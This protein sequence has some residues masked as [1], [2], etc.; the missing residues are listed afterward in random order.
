MENFTILAQMGNPE[1]WSWE[2]INETS[3]YDE[4]KNYGHIPGTRV[5]LGTKELK[6][7]K[8]QF[9]VRWEENNHILDKMYDTF[10]LALNFAKTNNG[11]IYLVKNGDILDRIYPKP[12]H[13]FSWEDINDMLCTAYFGKHRPV[14]FKYVVHGID[15]DRAGQSENW[16]EPVQYTRKSALKLKRKLEKE[17]VASWIEV[18]VNGREAEHEARMAQLEEDEDNPPCWTEGVSADVCAKCWETRCVS[19][20][21][22]I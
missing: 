16:L 10:K 7:D 5:F 6:F 11:Y 14:M 12:K 15:I 4:A 21:D 20:P 18:I 2:P 17:S 13:T 19:H 3:S 8:I 1:D 9:F 22:Y